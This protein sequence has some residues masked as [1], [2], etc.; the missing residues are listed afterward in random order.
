MVTLSFTGSEKLRNPLVELTG[1]RQEFLGTQQTWSTTYTVQAKDD[2]GRSPYGMEELV[3]WLDASNIDGRYNESLSD[4]DKVAEWIDLSGNGN[5]ASQSDSGKQP[6]FLS[7]TINSKGSISFDRNSQAHMVTNAY[8]TGSDELTVVAVFKKG[9]NE[10]HGKIYYHNSISIHH[11]HV[12]G[13]STFGAH[14]WRSGY[15]GR[16]NSDVIVDDVTSIGSYRYQK[17]EG[18]KAKLNF[19]GP[20]VG[21][22]SSVSYSIDSSS[23]VKYIGRHPS[24]TDEFFEGEIAELLVFNSALSDLELIKINTYLSQK[25][26]LESTVDSDGDGLKD[27]ED[28]APAGLIVESKPVLFNIVFEDEAGNRGMIADNTTDSTFIGID[29]TKPELLDVSIVSNNPDNTTAKSGDNV[30]LSFKTT[31]PIQTPTDSDITI[32]GLDT[33]VSIR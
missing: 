22:N 9:F 10:N 18:N 15:Y 24:A 13:S 33:L 21:E 17:G 30:T 29:T 4:G 6:E 26:G 16:I 23:S 27:F 28:D 20:Q 3:L 32:T 31:E 14:N 5:D 12:G 7:N 11:G 1:E 25:W 2:A 8:S 19:N